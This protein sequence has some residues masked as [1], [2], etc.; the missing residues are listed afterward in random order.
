MPRFVVLRH[1]TPPGYP[2][3]LHWDLM[4][5][6]EGALAT[7]ALEAEPVAGCSLTATVL[8]DH[9]LDFL[10]FEGP[11]SKERGEVSCYDA[12]IYETLAED[13]GSLVVRLRGRK[14]DGR[15]TIEKISGN[16][17]AVEIRFDP[18]PATSG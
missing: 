12:G 9:R 16:G 14:V 11:L 8:K 7:W 10:D 1:Q 4:L 18:Y 3:P 17:N 5:E 2:R 15:A 6:K 13:S